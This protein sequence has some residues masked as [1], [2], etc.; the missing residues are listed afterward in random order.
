MSFIDTVH[1]VK[2]PRM[3]AASFRSDEVWKSDAFLGSIRLRRLIG[4]AFNVRSHKYSPAVTHGS[5]GLERLPPSS[6]LICSRNQPLNNL[7][8]CKRQTFKLNLA[9]GDNIFQMGPPP[10]PFFLSLFAFLFCFFADIRRKLGVCKRQKPFRKNKHLGA[11]HNYTVKKVVIYP[12]R[13][14]STILTASSET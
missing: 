14:L 3:S 7:L 5:R 13:G 10:P 4:L 9:K 2:L 1:H 6:A 12:K 11:F 8:L